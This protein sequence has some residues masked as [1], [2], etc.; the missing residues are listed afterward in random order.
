MPEGD[1]TFVSL[2]LGIVPLLAKNWRALL[3]LTALPLIPAILVA[4]SPD[5]WALLAT[6]VLGIPVAIGAAARALS[7]FAE[8]LGHPRPYS[9]WIEVLFIAAIIVFSLRA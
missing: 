4:F 5:P 1:Y 2:G 3:L 7:L 8:R 6:A 9:L